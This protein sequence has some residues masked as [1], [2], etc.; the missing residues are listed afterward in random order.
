MAGSGL[1]TA[2]ENCYG[3]VSIGHMLNGKSVARAVRGHILIDSALNII[4]LQDILKPFVDAVDKRLDTENFEALSTLYDKVA[5][6][7]IDLKTDIEL[8]NAL[9]HLEH[10]YE[11]LK[12][13]LESS[14]RTAKLWLQYLNYIKIL[15]DFIC[16]ERLSNWN[17]HLNSVSKMLNLSAATGHRQYAKSA[18]LYLQLMLDLPQSNPW[19][20][21]KLSNCSLHAVRRSDR[22]WGGLATDLVIEQVMMKAVKSRGGLMHGRG[23]MESVCLIWVMNM[24]RVC[25]AAFCTD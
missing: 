21:N 16:A 6:K 23:M 7:T 8:T 19:L 12:K 9:Q 11:E 15:K 25:N 13:K 5:C 24:H 1:D 4:L 18:C 10:E 2:L 22:Y 20:H 14:S 17:L 3:P